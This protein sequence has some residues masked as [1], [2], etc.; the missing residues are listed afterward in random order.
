MRNTVGMRTKK[1]GG[2]ASVAALGAVAGA[3]VVRFRSRRTHRDLYADEDFGLIDAGRP[4]TVMA[5]DG[6]RLAVRESGSARAALTVIFVHG[7]SNR[8]TSFHLQRTL[9]AERWGPDVRM[10]FYDLRGHGKSGMPDT[11]H[12]TIDQLGDD[13][14]S[15]IRTV[16]PRGPV[17]LVGHSMGGMTIL[18][19]ARKYPELFGSQVAGIGL[20]STTA[21]GI[22]RSGL[23]S[24]LRN[25]AI[26]GFRMA[27]RA[28][29]G[30]VQ[31]GRVAAR[32]LIWP[33]LH[34]ASFRTEVSPSLAKFTYAMIDDTSVVTIVKFL[35]TLE[36]H[37]ESEALPVLAGLPAVIVSGDADMII[38]F[39]GAQALA[40]ALPDSELV[41][42]HGAGH[43][44]HLEFPEVVNDAI[45]RLVQR[46]VAGES[47]FDYDSDYDSDTDEERS[48][49][50]G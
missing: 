38:P 27:V 23:G 21:A 44:V 5:E 20:I 42:V 17:V 7:F 31:F 16:A 28:A 37:D 36:L 14:A 3:H 41:R 8:M 15:V 30:I 32:T 49:D 2:I 46:V 10:V 48:A 34:A 39:S 12:A 26:D 11:E 4:S 35:N 22:A 19:A 45:D 29:P 1:V 13:L 50:V 47:G 25:P 6:V 33:I 9:L 18:A 24:T 40:D 43:M